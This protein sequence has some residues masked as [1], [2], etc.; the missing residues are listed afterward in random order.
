MTAAF[1]TERLPET[2]AN[3]VVSTPVK[4]RP[5]PARPLRLVRMLSTTKP[6]VELDP[7]GGWAYEEAS[8]EQAVDSG[9]RL[10]VPVNG[11]SIVVPPPYSPR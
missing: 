4:A 2:G 8:V 3:P 1:P 7:E 10:G 9:V 5:G 6:P 11:T